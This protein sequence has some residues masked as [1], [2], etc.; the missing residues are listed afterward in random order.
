MT[1]QFADDARPLEDLTEL[2]VAA[3]YAPAEPDGDAAA[4]ARRLGRAARGR[5]A[6]RL[7]WRR[8]LGA[9]LSPRSLIPPQQ[10]ERVGAGRH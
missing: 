9:V 8:R 7:G 1:G 3:E 10:R 2:Y 6:G 4:A 5:L